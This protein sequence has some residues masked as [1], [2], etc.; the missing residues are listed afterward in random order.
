MLPRSVLVAF[1]FSDPSRRALHWA[2]ALRAGLAAGVSV[3]YVHDPARSAAPS[4]E[5]E[6]E[7]LVEALRREIDEVFGPDAQ[8]VRV[9]VASGL[10]VDRLHELALELGADL[11]IAGSTGKDA[12]ERVLLGSVTEELI[13]RSAI[14]VMIV[15]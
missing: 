7:R 2:R 15:H 10:A 13:R 14:P 5:A 6:R 8:A 12:V 1:D 11:L 9:R 4:A 3:V